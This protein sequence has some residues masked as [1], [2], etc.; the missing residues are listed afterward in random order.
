M[1]YRDFLSDLFA[2]GRTA[3]SAEPIGDEEVREGEAVL[4]DYERIHR[5][6]L[7]GS[8]PEFN[9]AAA[10]WAGARFYSACQCAVYR[11]I[12]EEAMQA[13]LG[14]DYEQP[15]TA[16]VHYSVDLTFRYLP[17][18]AK[19]AESTAEN[20]P[21]LDHMKRWACMWPLSSVGMPDVDTVHATE[22]LEDDSLIRL[23][24]DR[25]I[26][27]SDKSRL[28]DDR[29]KRQVR[30]AIGLFPELAQK[31]HDEILKQETAPSGE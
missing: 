29:V 19:F 16:S 4:A 24:A 26:A 12:A 27:K 9:L 18:I 23:Y 1:G 31:M 17:D 14:G 7:P 21:L 30:H 22:L 11:D 8:A 28:N 25:I 6:T 2:E 20:D 3:V 13:R 15:I 5:L 10:S